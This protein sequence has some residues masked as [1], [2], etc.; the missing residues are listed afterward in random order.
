MHRNM[1]NATK[2]GERDTHTHTE[3]PLKLA[4]SIDIVNKLNNM[5]QQYK[6]F[7]SLTYEPNLPLK[8]ASLR[9]DFHFSTIYIISIEKMMANQRLMG[10][11]F[12]QYIPLIPYIIY[13]MSVFVRIF[14][15]HLKP[16]Y[17]LY[18]WALSERLVS[19]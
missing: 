9:W 14:R 15:L 18:S 12:T 3:W 17:A 1:N 19:T 2:K 7:Q 6:R 11:S 8:L 13:Q 10:I 5:N 4:K 16:V